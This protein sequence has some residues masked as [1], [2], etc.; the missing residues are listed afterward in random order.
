M[1]LKNSFLSLFEKI[2]LDFFSKRF[3]FQSVKLDLIKSYN[4]FKTS[5]ISLMFFL[6]DSL[7]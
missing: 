6:L 7:T 5:V 4:N 1:P 3:S 2:I